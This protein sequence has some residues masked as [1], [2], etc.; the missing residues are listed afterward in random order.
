MPLTQNQFDQFID[1]AHNGQNAIEMVMQAHQTGWSYGL[2][3][4]DCSMPV[5]NGY[6]STKAIRKFNYEH[7]INQPLIVACTGHTEDEYI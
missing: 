2:I 7:H 5:M 1:S 6:E 4:M 3:F